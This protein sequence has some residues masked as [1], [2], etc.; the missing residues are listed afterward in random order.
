MKF[1]TIASGSKGN[2]IYVSNKNTG[3]FIDA[4]VSWRVTKNFLNEMGQESIK[5]IFITH[6]HSDHIKNLKYL[7]LNLHA[8]VFANKETLDVICDKGCIGAGCEGYRLPIGKT[9]DMGDLSVTSFATSHDAVNSVGYVIS[10]GN[11]SLAVCTDT[12]VVLNSAMDALMGCELI[13]IESNHDEQMLFNGSYPPYLKDR[14]IGPK[15]HLSNTDCGNACVKL[16]QGGL[17]NII[18][19]HIS[20][21]NNTHSLARNTVCGILK[22]AGAEDGK[23]YTLDIADQYQP[24]D[25]YRI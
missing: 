19:G 2:S 23:D 4:G 5:G 1:R 3:I 17:K 15:G 20:E 14:I 10:D 8:P 13:L 16:L 12:G 7:T 9:A 21:E 24:S 18:L 25:T 11:K 22:L 6:E